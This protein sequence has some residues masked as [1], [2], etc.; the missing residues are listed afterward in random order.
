MAQIEPPVL[1]HR[2]FRYRP[3]ASST[4]NREIVAIKKQ[5]IYCSLYHSL[6]DPMEGFYG[7]SRRL[8]SHR[9]Y[10]RIVDK[11]FLLKQRIG[12]CCFTDTPDNE[13][14][15][16]HYASNYAGICVAYSSEKLVAGLPSEARLARLGYGSEPPRLSSSDAEAAREAAIKVLSHKKASWSYEREW[17]VLAIPGLTTLSGEGCVKEVRLGS[18]IAPSHEQQIT[19]ALDGFG[20]RISKMT[21]IDYRHQ[22]APVRLVK[23]TRR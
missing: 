9:N 13:L 14:M 10:P 15:W 8:Q 16:T 12:I 19:K 5:Q 3:L 11:L 20:I 17:R 23:R 1:P 6:N 2:L 7:P 18:R 21:V 4:L 22:W